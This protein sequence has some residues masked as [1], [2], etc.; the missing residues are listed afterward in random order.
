MVPSIFTENFPKPLPI[1]S[2]PSP[3]DE[4]CFLES[5]HPPLS[6]TGGSRAVA[7]RRRIMILCK[8]AVISKLTVTRDSLM[9]S[10]LRSLS[11]FTPFS[12]F[13]F[14]YLSPSLPSHSAFCCQ[15][16]F[17]PVVCVRASG[18]F[19]LKSTCSKKA[20]SLEGT[21]V[22][23]V[24]Q[25]PWFFILR[26]VQLQ[27]SVSNSHRHLSSSAKARPFVFKIELSAYN[28]RGG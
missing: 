2:S 6:G 10:P 27:R 12:H 8:S 18:R 7:Q 15:G 3:A 28:E 16:L 20:P 22:S 19:C 23:P 13:H 9:R 26:W 21:G 5:R 14:F 4:Y 25:P 17:L 1:R 24:L 11:V